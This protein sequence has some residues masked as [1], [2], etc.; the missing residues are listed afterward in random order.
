MKPAAMPSRVSRVLSEKVS[1]L[2]ARPCRTTEQ[3]LTARRLS[4]FSGRLLASPPPDAENTCR[5]RGPN[6]APG[7]ACRKTQARS[8]TRSRGSVRD[9]DSSRSSNRGFANREHADYPPLLAFEYTVVPEPS[10]IVLL[11]TGL[12]M[13]LWRRRGH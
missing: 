2:R 13:L 5:P 7:D 4:P 12:G 6:R 9:E 3:T 8:R 11:L 10:A 1:W